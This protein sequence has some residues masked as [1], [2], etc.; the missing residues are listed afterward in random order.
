MKDAVIACAEAR[1][2]GVSTEKPF[3]AVLADADE[4]V[5]ACESRNVV[6]A[7]G[8]LVRAM[9]E[10]QAAARRIRTGEFGA[11]KGAGLHSW[12]GEISGGGCQHVSLL[13]LFTDSRWRR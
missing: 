2:R 13:R 6:F 4:M 1:V 11:L 8:N 10:A 7:G 12:G 5:Q 9:N 3:A